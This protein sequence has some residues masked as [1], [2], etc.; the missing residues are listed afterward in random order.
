MA[1][2]A[3]E[4]QNAQ[5]IFAPRACLATDTERSLFVSRGNFSSRWGALTGPAFDSGL[6]DDYRCDGSGN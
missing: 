1:I 4:T 3:R 5:R 2:T 6:I